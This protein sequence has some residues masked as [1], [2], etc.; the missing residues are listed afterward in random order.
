MDHANPVPMKRSHHYIGGGG[1]VSG[2]GAWLL[3]LPGRPT[4]LDNNKARAYCARRRCEWGCLANFLSPVI[5]L[6]SPSLSGRRLDV[7]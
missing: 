3:L 7:D 6:L 1:G 2:H 4:N 5:S